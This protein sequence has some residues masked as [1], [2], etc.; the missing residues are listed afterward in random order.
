[1]ALPLSS[2]SPC[3]PLSLVFF[4]PLREHRGRVNSDHR[5]MAFKEKYLKETAMKQEEE[6]GGRKQ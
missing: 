1:M 4:H 3:P 5:G 2:P 6:E